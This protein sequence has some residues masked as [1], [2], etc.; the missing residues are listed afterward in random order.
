MDFKYKILIVDDDKFLLNMYTIKFKK[1][2]A[3]I[4]T[5]SGGQEAL[6]RLR[7]GFEPDALIVDIV[8]PGMDGFEFVNRVRN[9]KLAQKAAVIFLT[10]QGQTP[11]IEKA[12]SL[13]VD[14]YIVKASSIPSEVVEKVA[15]IL[16]NKNKK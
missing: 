4:V 2:G 1:S 12:K 8:M 11:D 3:D 10:N 9:E 6:N 7:A 15:E 14:G 5:S 13:N 16:K